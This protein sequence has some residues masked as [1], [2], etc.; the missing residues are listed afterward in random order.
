MGEWPAR[1]LTHICTPQAQAIL[2]H[3]AHTVVARSLS[4]SLAKYW[5]LLQS[6]TR[7]SGCGAATRQLSHHARA[8]DCTPAATIGTPAATDTSTGQLP[9]HSDMPTANTHP[10]SLLQVPQQPC[11]W[12]LQGCCRPRARTVT[13]TTAAPRPLFR[14]KALRHSATRGHS[15][16]PRARQAHIVPHER[17]LDTLA[18]CGLGNTAKRLQCSAP[19]SQSLPPPPP[20][21]GAPCPHLHAAPRQWIRSSDAVMPAQPWHATP[22]P[23]IRR[24]APFRT[25]AAR[26][27][28]SPRQQLRCGM[29]L[30]HHK[31]AAQQSGKR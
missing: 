5:N 15:G 23:C 9:L 20:P 11:L 24:G 14:P 4:H 3:H 2:G 1:Q 21:G 10:K 30:P 29:R 18:W 22:R 28:D 7:A 26:R 25:F 19:C 17:P 13:R 31:R 6:R 16:G 27:R 12:P 8:R